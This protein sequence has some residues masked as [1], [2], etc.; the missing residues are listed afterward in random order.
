MCGSS[1]RAPEEAR[2]N[3][4]GIE[5]KPGDVTLTTAPSI[6]LD[7]P[8]AL[9]FAVVALAVAWATRRRASLG[10]ALLVCLVPFALPR[11]VGPTTVTL[12]KAGLA[13][14]VAGLAVSRTRP[15]LPRGEAMR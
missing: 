10:V 9:L 11:Y 1:P 3:P 7:V 5:W 4:F 14:F 2:V 12:F 6:P 15:V 8:S 13:G